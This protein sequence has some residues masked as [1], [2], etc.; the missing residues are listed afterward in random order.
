MKLALALRD[1]LLRNI[2]ARWKE[3]VGEDFY[4]QYL[5]LRLKFLKARVEQVG[6]DH[7]IEY[8]I[9]DQ[10]RPEKLIF[11]PGFGDSKENFYNAAQFLVNDCDVMI[12]DMP[13]FGRSFKR[14][15]E[16]YSLTNYTKWMSDFIEQTGWVDFHL[17]GNS[18]GGAVGVKLALSM[19]ERI[20]SLTLVD[21]AGIVLPDQPSIYQEFLDDRNIFAIDTPLQFEYFLNRVYHTPPVIPPFIWDHIYRDYQKHSKW[22]KKVL[23]DLLEGV[24]TLDDPR[25]DEFT[26]NRHLKHVSVPTMIVWGDEDTFFPPATADYVH[27]QI[28]GSVLYLLADRGHGPQVEAP[29]QFAQLMKK[30]MRRHR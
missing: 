1:E 14:K 4:E 18:L 9:T 19:P 16:T 27:S 30:F 15:G 20:K 17:V 25:L 5:K 12:P 8:M 10:G 28:P 26:L 13:G 21:C 29:L 22:H 2:P 24:Q 7:K 6:G 11:L 3:N 23:S